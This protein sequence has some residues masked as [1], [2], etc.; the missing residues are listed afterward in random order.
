MRD[1]TYFCSGASCKQ[2]KSTQQQ[3]GCQFPQSINFKVS[4][5]SDAKIT[6]IRLQYS[7]DMLGFAQIVS[8]A[9]VPIQSSTKVDTQWNW[10]LTENWRF[11]P[12]H[13]YQIPVVIKRCQQVTSIKTSLTEV[14]FDD[15]R[16]TWNS[17]VQDKV[18]I[19]GIRATSPLARQSCKPLRM[20]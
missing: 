9:Y 16:Y 17:L 11:T 8:E 7:I 6:E 5:Q 3:R 15:G 13:H 1:C 2:F 4:A 10:D 18:T 12:G 20:L 14:K 19:S